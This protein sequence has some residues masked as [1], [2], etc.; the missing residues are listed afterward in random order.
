MDWTHTRTV[1]RLL[2]R[3]E[4]VYNL[5]FSL[6]DMEKWKWEMCW[7][8]VIKVGAVWMSVFAITRERD[9]ISRVKKQKPIKTHSFHS[10]GAFHKCFHFIKCFSGNFNLHLDHHLY[11]H[12]ADSWNFYWTVGIILDLKLEFVFYLWNRNGEDK[13]ELELTFD[14]FRNDGMEQLK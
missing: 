3:F 2:C 13:V 7:C 12:A 4:E 9:E 6:L 14:H 5:T 1:Q 11:L 8:D 10:W